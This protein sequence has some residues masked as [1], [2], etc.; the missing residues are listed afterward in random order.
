MCYIVLRLVKCFDIPGGCGE[1]WLFGGM[2]EQRLMLLWLCLM[3]VTQRTVFIE[4]SSWA[5][6]TGEW[7][8]CTQTV[9]GPTQSKG[10]H[11]L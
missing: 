2:S 1:N 11:T 6:Q 4:R 10:P 8:C 3:C 9:K 7:Y 5:Q